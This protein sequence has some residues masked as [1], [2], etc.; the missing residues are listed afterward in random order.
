MMDFELFH[1]PRCGKSREA[2]K[3]L[4]KKGVEPKVRLYLSDPPT[5]KEL[6]DILRKL[7]IRAAELIRFREEIAS[8]LGIKPSDDRPDSE[9][10]KLMVENPILIER[11]ILISSNK[12]VIGRPPEAVLKL[13]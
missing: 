6:S 3:I 10:V 5:P 13:I 7:G 2:L 1:N 8:E 4:Q 11:P 12:A 9:W